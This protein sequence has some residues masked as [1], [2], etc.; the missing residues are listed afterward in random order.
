MT[1]LKYS[2]LSSLLI[3]TRAHAEILNKCGAM[4]ATMNYDSLR[5]SLKLFPE[6]LLDFF[7]VTAIYIVVFATL[8]FIIR[9]FRWRRLSYLTLLIAITMPLIVISEFFSDP[10]GTKKIISE[11]PFGHAAIETSYQII[12][13]LIPILAYLRQRRIKI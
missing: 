11:L 13:M 5:F 1:I 7:F 9:K 6:A 8:E 3:N 10:C 12:F 2:A 4:V